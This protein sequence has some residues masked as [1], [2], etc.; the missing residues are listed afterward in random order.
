[1]HKFFIS[2]QKKMDSDKLRG[3]SQPVFRVDLVPE[4]IT[5]L[6]SVGLKDWVMLRERLYTSSA[7]EI[8]SALVAYKN[9]FIARELAEKR[10]YSTIKTYPLDAESEQLYAK[11]RETKQIDQAAYHSLCKLLQQSP[12]SVHH[13]EDWD[14][15]KN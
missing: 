4:Y 11:V 6:K 8:M 14:R 1:M 7:D 13:P 9:A 3:F 12:S 15:I 10:W 2:C 5:V